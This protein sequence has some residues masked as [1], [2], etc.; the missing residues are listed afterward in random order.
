MSDACSMPCQEGACRSVSV[1]SV[2]GTDISRIADY[3]ENLRMSLGV[4]LELLSLLICKCCHHCY[5]QTVM[6]MVINAIMRVFTAL[7]GVF[8]S[9]VQ[10]DYNAKFDSS[11]QT[12]KCPPSRWTEP[13]CLQILQTM[14]PT[15]RIWPR[16]SS[17]MVIRT[18]HDILSSLARRLPNRWVNWL[19]TPPRWW[20]DASQVVWAWKIISGT[21]VRSWTMCGRY[22][23]NRTFSLLLLTSNTLVISC[24]CLWCTWGMMISMISMSITTCVPNIYVW[25]FYICLMFQ[26]YEQACWPS[27]RRILQSTVYNIPQFFSWSPDFF[28]TFIQKVVKPINFWLKIWLTFFYCNFFWL[29]WKLPF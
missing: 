20:P 10:L 24:G 4:H 18:I 28:S 7:T 19:W 9:P 11:A 27:H 13:V 12:K 5:V 8:F 17:S 6:F 15:I 2:S 16:D 1:V 25:C 21:T 23:V 22:R 26:L 3:A 14:F 29:R